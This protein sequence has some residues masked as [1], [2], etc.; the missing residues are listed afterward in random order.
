LTQG[1]LATCFGV[2]HA[3]NGRN[4]ALRLSAPGFR[5]LDRITAVDPTGGAWGVGLA[6]AEHDLQRDAWYF[7]C[8]FKDDLCIPGTVVGEGC[9]QLLQFYMLHLGLHTQTTNARFQPVPDRKLVA[10]SRGQI[11]P[12]S[13]TL[14]YRLEA[15]DMGL[16]PHPYAIANVDVLFAGKIIARCNNI[17][18]QLVE[19]GASHV[20]DNRS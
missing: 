14:S 18:L 3:Q 6:Q 17:G 1:D 10:Q 9:V 7:R 4:P 12:Q 19:E 15:T 20:G 5:R 16:A 11:T 8:H 13:G 2:T